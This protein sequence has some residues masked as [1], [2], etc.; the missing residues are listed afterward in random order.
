MLDRAFKQAQLITLTYLSMFARSSIKD[1][2]SP[3]KH[4]KRKATTHVARIEAKAA[5]VVDIIN[6][7]LRL[8]LFDWC[9]RV[10]AR[11]TLRQ[12][13]GISICDTFESW[14]VFRKNISTAIAYLTM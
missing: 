2:Y 14:T 7:A 9:G 8:I 12:N 1:R 4:A 3:S 6:D 13:V 10:L 11:Q 5:S